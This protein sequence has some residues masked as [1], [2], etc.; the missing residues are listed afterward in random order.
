M[1]CIDSI[2]AKSDDSDHYGSRS[3]GWLSALGA[4]TEGCPMSAE[5]SDRLRRL[6]LEGFGGGDFTVVDEVG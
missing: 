2:D 4:V 6:L 1:H 5:D 3:T